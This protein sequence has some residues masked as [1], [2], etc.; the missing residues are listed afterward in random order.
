METILTF[1]IISLLTVFTI[2]TLQ[3]RR[4]DL[5]GGK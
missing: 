1:M 5:H 2:D 4:R 3:K